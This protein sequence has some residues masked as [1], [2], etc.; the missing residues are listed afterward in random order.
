M[1]CAVDFDVPP[2]FFKNC[3]LGSFRQGMVRTAV[4]LSLF[5][6]IPHVLLR[7]LALLCTIRRLLLGWLRS[8]LGLRCFPHP[9]IP[10]LPFQYLVV[11]L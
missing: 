7:L 10:L 6:T 5:R 1:E 9:I 2:L 8:L 11:F 3:D 4:Q